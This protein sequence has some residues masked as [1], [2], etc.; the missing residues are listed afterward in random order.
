MSLAD[1]IR[2]LCAE[3]VNTNEPATLFYSLQELR[4]IVRDDNFHDNMKKLTE[5]KPGIS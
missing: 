2:E 3:A 4:E 1:R 5:D